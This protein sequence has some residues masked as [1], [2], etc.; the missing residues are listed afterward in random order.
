MTRK[1]HRI[2]KHPRIRLNNLVGQLPALRQ[3]DFSNTEQAC[4]GLLRRTE[5]DLAVKPSGPEF[6]AFRRFSCSPVK[7]VEAKRPSPPSSAVGRLRPGPAKNSATP[8]ATNSRA[9]GMRPLLQAEWEVGGW[10]VE[11]PSSLTRAVAMHRRCSLYNWSQRHPGC[12]FRSEHWAKPLQ[13]ISSVSPSHNSTS[14]TSALP[15]IGTPR[16]RQKRPRTPPDHHR[17]QDWGTFKLLDPPPVFLRP[18][19]AG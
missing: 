10:K 14:A 16:T 8:R 9:L 15:A 12:D 18:R 19:A 3:P 7:P 2:P 5:L 11:I 1:A 13:S 17:Q 4:S 6:L